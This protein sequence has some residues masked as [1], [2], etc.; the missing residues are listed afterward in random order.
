MTQIQRYPEVSV[1][2][3]LIEV[4]QAIF[5]DPQEVIAI[6]RSYPDNP[7]AWRSPNGFDP[8]LKVVAPCIINLR[9]GGVHI[10]QAVMVILENGDDYEIKVDSEEPDAIE[11]DDYIMDFISAFRQYRQH[12]LALSVKERGVGLNLIGGKI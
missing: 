8:Q 9:H 10:D 6:D 12:P 7:F 4:A 5:A 3:E 1:G 11:P 2:R